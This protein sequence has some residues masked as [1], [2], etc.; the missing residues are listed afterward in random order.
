[1]ER[2][3]HFRSPCVIAEKQHQPKVRFLM[4]P[5]IKRME[6]QIPPLLNKISKCCKGSHDITY[7]MIAV[8]HI[9]LSGF[10]SCFLNTGLRTTI[11]MHW[12]RVKD[13]KYLESAPHFIKQPN[14]SG[15]AI[16]LPKVVKNAKAPFLPRFSTSKSKKDYKPEGHQ[17]GVKH[18]HVGHYIFVFYHSFIDC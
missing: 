1:M 13:M 8:M 16:F 6:T 15:H 9:T 7:H 14:Q 11:S 3:P 2:K 17:I 10:S 4:T 5:L 18:Y 12:C